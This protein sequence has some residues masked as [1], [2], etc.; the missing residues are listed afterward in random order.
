MTFPAKWR[1]FLLNVQKCAAGGAWGNHGERSCINNG[2]TVPEGRPLLITIDWRSL[3]RR[4]DPLINDRVVNTRLSDVKIKAVNGR[5][6]L[7]SR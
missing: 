4:Y 1:H 6:L 3:Q 7:P 2:H 5:R